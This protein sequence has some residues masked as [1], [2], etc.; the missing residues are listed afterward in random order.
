MASMSDPK[1]FFRPGG[2]LSRKLPSYEPRP[3]Q[4]AMAEAVEGAIANNETLLVEAGTGVGKSLA[5][6]YPFILWAAR[7]ENKVA[8]ST[9]TKTLQKQLIEKDVPFLRDEVGL[10]IRAELCLGAGNYLCPYRFEKASRQGLFQSKKAADQFRKVEKW[11]EKTAEGLVLELDFVPLSEVWS[12]VKVETD[13]CLHGKCPS[14]DGCFY[15]RARRRQ[16][17]ADILVMNHHLFFANLAVGGAVLPPFQAVVF[18]E[19]HSL[20][21]IA[22]EF[23]G[24]QFSNYR[25]P[26][27]LGYLYG[28]RTKKGFLPTHLKN[29]VELADWER[30]I[31]KLHSLNDDFFSAL[32]KHWPE[33]RKTVR[34]R[35][36]GYAGD[37]LTGPL[38]EL[39]RR[40]K[41]LREGFGDEE[42]REE[43]T[44]YI[45]R[46]RDLTRD[47][48][49]LLNLKLEGYVY[50]YERTRAIRRVR[51]SLQ[52]API[53]VGEFLREKLWDRPWPVVL[54][55]ATLSTG[56]N[57]RFICSNLGLENCRSLILDSP[58]DYPRRVIVY[59]DAK[60]P[61]PTRRRQEY[62]EKIIR[63][64]EE[65]VRL[66]EGGAF[67][68]FTSFRMLDRAYEELSEKLTE[69]DCLR[70]GDRDRY[71]LLEEF[72]ADPSSVLFG[73]NSFWQGVDVPGESLKCVIIVKLPFDVPDDP[74]T[75]A[76]LEDI[77]LKGGDPFRAYQ[78]PRAVIMLRQGFG[79]LMRGRGDYGVVAILDPRIHTRQYGR[80]FLASLPS[81]RVT[82]HLTHVEE[83]LEKVKNSHPVRLGH[84]V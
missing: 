8:V 69:Y 1:E 58:F 66:T 63:D 29:E 60:I 4:A 83:F 25:L 41:D 19:A 3:Q 68:L 48:D 24:V 72:K 65:I 15:Y 6:L 16:E 13:L 59:T 50:W 38:E 21:A 37:V 47:L 82:S 74:L 54:T 12:S 67:V 71:R 2:E 61:D 40:L 9:E 39:T 35:E 27:L 51:H 45:S 26:R 64:I 43:A 44:G 70:Q 28:R 79:R 7:G 80:E 62:E 5:Y 57:F 33:D 17:K 20:E 49:S 53:R 36:A 14:L 75:E 32:E 23:L 22:T 78:V 42:S 73:T 10:P 56:G 31:D 11:S 81:C 76:R 46:C 77:R 18:D 52:M 34:I 55:S 30:L 84:P